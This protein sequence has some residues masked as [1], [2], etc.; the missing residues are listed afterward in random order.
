MAEMTDLSYSAEMYAD[1]MAEE[2]PVVR[3][4]DLA[5]DAARLMA[6]HRLPGLVV[7]TAEGSPCSVLPASEVVKFLVPPLRP[8]SSH[9]GRGVVGIGGRP[10]RG[11]TGRQDGP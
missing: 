10:D 11:Q 9:P 3:L 5:L 7:T 2:F 6:D 1:V 8:G 4:D